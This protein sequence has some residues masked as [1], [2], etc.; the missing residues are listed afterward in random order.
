MGVATREGK[1]PPQA[2]LKQSANI[3]CE[4]RRE[5]LA[6]Q[7]SWSQNRHTRGHFKLAQLAYFSLKSCDTV[8]KRQVGSVSHGGTLLECWNAA[9]GG[10]ARPSVGETERS[11]GALP[12]PRG[13]AGARCASGA[14]ALPLPLTSYLFP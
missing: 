13:P 8:P 1:K 2:R 4:D 3:E 11:G 14:P 10:E 7:L 6:S 9:G 5:G 12:T